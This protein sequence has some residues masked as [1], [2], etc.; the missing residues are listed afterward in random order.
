MDILR[1]CKIKHLLVLNS[2]LYIHTH[3]Q[4]SNLLFPIELKINVVSTAKSY[5]LNK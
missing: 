3:T 4:F 5:E 1:P 2:V